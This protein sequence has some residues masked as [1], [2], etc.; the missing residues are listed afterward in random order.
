MGKT[1]QLLYLL[2]ENPNVSLDHMLEIGKIIYHDFSKNIP[3]LKKTV[4]L[5]LN[6]KQLMKK[7]KP[8]F[9]K[10]NTLHC[11]KSTMHC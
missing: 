5:K 10:T 2:F 7:Q 3:E 6:K 11:W 1:R 8:N 4:F 9:G